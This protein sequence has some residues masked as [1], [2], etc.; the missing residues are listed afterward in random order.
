M[1]ISA[2]DEDHHGDAGAARLLAQVE[3]APVEVVLRP[4]HQVDVA[5]RGVRSRGRRSPAGRRGRSAGR[6]GRPGWLICSR[7]LGPR[8]GELAWR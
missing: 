6:A 4:R 1:I 7:D 8:L 3:A 5:V 2:D